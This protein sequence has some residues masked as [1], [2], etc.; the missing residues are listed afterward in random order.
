MFDMSLP[1]SSSIIDDVKFIE[2]TLCFRQ[3][4]KKNCQML[5]F[6]ATYEGEVMKFAQS[7]IPNPVTISLRREEES[8]DNIKQVYIT[9][10]DDTEKFEAL[11]NIYGVLSIGQAMI[12]CHVSINWEFLG[13]QRT[14]CLP[15]NAD[16]VDGMVLDFAY[17]LMF[18]Y[19]RR[20]KK[21]I[22]WPLRW[23]E[24]DTRWH[25]SVVNLLLNKG[26]L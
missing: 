5:L 24:K 23:W 13:I 10:Q 7:I 12:F 6:S 2:I 17:V 4:D 19:F 18:P 3:L 8:L 15:F 22:G 14:N 11:S 20:R 1:I 9:C 26:R 25:F 16:D 21:Q